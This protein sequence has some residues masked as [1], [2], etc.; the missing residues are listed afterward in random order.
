M[1]G[2]TEYV[3]HFTRNGVATRIPRARWNRIRDGEESVKEYANLQMYIAYAYILLENRKPDYCP[4]ID[5][6]VYYFEQNGYIIDNGP[7]YIDVFQDYE[8]ETGGVISLEHRKKKK[9]AAAKYHWELKQAQIQ[10]VIDCIW[11]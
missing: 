11:K 4:R 9:E 8:E 6:A 1:S 5:G 10:Q 3:F 7:H 2:I